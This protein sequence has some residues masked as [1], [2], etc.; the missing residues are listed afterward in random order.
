ML[1]ANVSIWSFQ[2]SPRTIRQR[3]LLRYL[4]Q[5]LS[6]VNNSAIKQFKLGEHLAEVKERIMQLIVP[7]LYVLSHKMDKDREDSG[8]I[9]KTLEIVCTSWCALLGDSEMEQESSE[10]ISDILSMVL[11]PSVPKGQRARRESKGNRDHIDQKDDQKLALLYRQSIRRME[12]AVNSSSSA[13]EAAA[14]RNEV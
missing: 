5:A 4:C 1:A 9:C 3:I 14:A 8:E 6:E 2:P 12:E 10:R 11:D 7:V 13:A